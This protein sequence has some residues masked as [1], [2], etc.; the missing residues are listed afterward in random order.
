MTNQRWARARA[1]ATPMNTVSCIFGAMLLF[2][3]ATTLLIP[4][5]RRAIVTFVE[6]AR[7]H[8]RHGAVSYVAVYALVTVLAFPV[9]MFAA[10]AGYIFP[11]GTAVLVVWL[12]GV[13]GACAAFVLGR[14]CFRSHI[15]RCFARR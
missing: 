14:L 15:R 6:W 3:T 8:P 13:L 4:E 5:S 1:C 2:G 9:T 12:G 10:V 11:F 7:E